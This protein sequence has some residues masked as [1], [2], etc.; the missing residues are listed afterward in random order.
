MRASL[1]AL[2]CSAG[3]GSWP[4]LAITFDLPAEGDLIGEIQIVKPH[5]RHRM[6]D[7]GRAYSMGFQEMRLANPEIS[8]WNQGAAEELV[9]PGRFILP[10]APR[11]GI[12]LNLAERRLYYFFTDPRTEQARVSTYPVGIGRLDRQTPT[13]QTRVT[14]KLHN[15]TWYPTAG[16]RA[17]YAKRG[18]Q[19]PSKIPPGPDNPLGEYALILGLPS[20]LIHGTHRPDGVGMQVS[21]GCIRMFPEDIRVLVEQVPRGT[22]VSFIDQPYKV[23]IAEDQLWLEVHPGVD[24]D[25]EQIPADEQ[26]VIAHIAAFL[27]N[28]GE[29][30]QGSVDWRK[31]NEVIARADGMPAVISR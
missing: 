25:D 30:W 23:G 26:R 2:L 15:P 17:D 13:A 12:V 19:L 18:I 11:E 7:I 22:S 3:L 8:P 1:L 21:Q 5:P 4:A 31:V 29:Q 20:Y 9:V 6:L 27:D 14:N 28:L 10:N 24:E 16:V